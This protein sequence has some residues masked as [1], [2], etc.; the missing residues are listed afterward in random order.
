[1]QRQQGPGGE[2]SKPPVSGLE[3]GLASAHAL[4]QNE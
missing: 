2:N 4:G 3:A 1:M